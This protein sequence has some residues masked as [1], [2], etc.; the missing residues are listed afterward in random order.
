[1]S[2]KI[3]KHATSTN[4]FGIANKLKTFRKNDNKNKRNNNSFKQKKRT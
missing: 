2:Y 3:Y 4:S 1:M